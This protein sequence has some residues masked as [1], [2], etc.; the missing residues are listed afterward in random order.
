LI[1]VTVDKQIV[2]SQTDFREA[3]NE[4]KFVEQAEDL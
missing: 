2:F 4:L 1:S 3:E